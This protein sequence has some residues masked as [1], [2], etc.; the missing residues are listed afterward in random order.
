MEISRI[1]QVLHLD[2]VKVG[3]GELLQGINPWQP[4]LIGPDCRCCTK[5]PVERWSVALDRRDPK[6][7]L[8]R[9][10]LGLEFSKIME[11]GC[12]KGQFCFHHIYIYQPLCEL[13]ITTC[14]AHSVRDLSL[15]DA[16]WCGDRNGVTWSHGRTF[17]SL[18]AMVVRLQEHQALWVL[19]QHYMEQNHCETIDRTLRQYP[20]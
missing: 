1:Q 19:V 17:P 3:P 15:F 10:L 14:S 16:V 18:A 4:W 9:L 13:S 8:R 2:F 7:S 20:Q 5:N 11:R 6:K 12:Y